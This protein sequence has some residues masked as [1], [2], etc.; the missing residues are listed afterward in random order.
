MVLEGITAQLPG[1]QLVVFIAIILLFLLSAGITAF[2]ILSR[3]RW[4][5]S[6]VVLED[7]AGKG[8]SI[9]RRGKARLIGFGD[10]GEEIFILKH[11]NKYRVGYGKRIG[12]K[13]IGWAIGEDGLWYQ[14]SFGDL[15]K[16]LL[17]LGVQPVSVNVRLAM[18]S[19]RKGLDKRYE[20]QSWLE[21]YGPILYFGMF[22]LVLFIFGGLIW[23][24]TNKQVEI[25]KINA[26]SINASK[27]TQQAAQQTLGLVDNILSRLNLNAASPT[28]I[29]N[30]IIGGSGLAPVP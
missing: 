13:Q 11:V 5:F 21:K 22:I 26:E 23:Y 9:S 4:P 15:N 29:N 17:E 27:E 6:Y 18:S 2:V 25:A 16:K 10:G 14:F 20:E 19:V 28:P 24:S 3:M 7:V 30:T 8:Y 1:W 12:P